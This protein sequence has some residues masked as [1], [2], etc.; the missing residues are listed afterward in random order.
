MQETAITIWGA[1]I[2]VIG[3]GRIGKAVAARLRALGA[4]VT[5]SARTP[6]DLAWIRVNGYTPALTGELDDTLSGYDVIVNTVPARILG[7]QRLSEIADTSLCLDLASKPGGIDFPAAARLGVRAMWALSLP[8]EVA[9]TT[10]GM[11][12]RDTV[13]NILRE[14]GVMT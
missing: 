13:Y 7:E 8:G 14:Q 4:D 1:K 2:L 11:I 3:Y 9:P 12:I 6:S 5:V 10:S